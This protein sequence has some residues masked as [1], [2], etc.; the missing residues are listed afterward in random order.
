VEKIKYLYRAY[1][2]KYLL[3]NQEITYI[4]SNLKKGDIA[5]DIGCHKGA[6][7]YWL[8][9]KVGHKGK[10]FAFE[11]QTKLNN[12][13]HVIKRIFNYQNVVIENKGLSSEQKTLSFYIPTTKSGSSPGARID[14]LEKDKKQDKIQIEVI[15]LD[16]YF[17]KQQIFP[18]FIKIDVEGHEKQVLL[19]GLELLKQCKPKIIMEC[20]NR[21]LIE[22]DIFD[23]F[24]V[25]LQ[26]GYK[27]FFIA[28]KKIRPLSEFNLDIHQKTLEVNFWKKKTYINNFIFETP[29]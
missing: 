5:V 22:G 18:N 17:L 7:L 11:P 28:D 13:L 12:Y 10:V 14:L 8:Q 4:I 27:G 20:E 26:I 16:D 3:D 15:R 21:H 19:G 25:L 6:Y 29:N 24:D 23:V 2:Y 9:K 1:R